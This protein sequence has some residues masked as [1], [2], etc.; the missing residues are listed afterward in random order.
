MPI[1]PSDKGVA[2]QIVYEK[3]PHVY[4]LTLLRDVD[5][6]KAGVRYV[7]QSMGNRRGYVTGGRIPVEIAKRYG[8]GVFARETIAASHLFTRD[9][10]SDLERAYIKEYDCLE[11]GMNLYRGGA[12][13]KEQRELHRY[14]LEGVYIDSWK[15][16]NE[17]LDNFYGHESYL[18][19]CIRTLRYSN[20]TTN[21]SFGG[22]LWSH[23]KLE[24]VN[25]FKSAKTLSVYQY[26]I[27]GR[28]IQSFDSLTKATEGTNRKGAGHIPEVMDMPN[29]TAA[30]FQWRS[31][32]TPRIEPFKRAP[33]VSRPIFMCDNEFNVIEKFSSVVEASECSGEQIS[34][35]HRFLKSKD[36]TAFNGG[37]KWKYC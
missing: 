14:S 35:I 10:L 15:S 25:R 19:N 26:D 29:K 1:L 27:D 32:Y 33:K 11:R 37:H 34:K 6:W 30:G 3:D 20:T 5:G 4:S 31:Y 9:I 12:G 36:K 23:S 22:F 8:W 16:K 13:N 18:R 28:F 2:S 17:V 21:R 24:R 7:G